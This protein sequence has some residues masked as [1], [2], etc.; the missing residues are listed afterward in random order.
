[1]TMTVFWLLVVSSRELCTQRAAYLFEI[2]LRVTLEARYGHSR[3]ILYLFEHLLC[4][5]GGPLRCV[6]M[7]FGGAQ[8]LPGPYGL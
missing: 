1:M 4:M 8:S 2:C 5:A 3:I 6:P 7:L